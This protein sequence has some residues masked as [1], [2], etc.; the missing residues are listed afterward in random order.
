M[1]TYE[2]GGP[3]LINPVILKSKERD[4]YECYV[5]KSE[6]REFH[7][8]RLEMQKAT[9]SDAFYSPF[10]FLGIV[11]EGSGNYSS[12]EIVIEIK[13]FQQFFIQANT[14]FMFSTHNKLKLYL[15]GS[16]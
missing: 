12:D 6:F 3:H 15:C 11:L 9:E 1:L 14:K 10:P 2:M 8:V 5:Y 7:C 4:N 13:E 16:W